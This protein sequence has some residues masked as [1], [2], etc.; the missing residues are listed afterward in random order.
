MLQNLTEQAP[1]GLLFDNRIGTRRE[2]QR[3]ILSSRELAYMLGVSKSTFYRKLK[4]GEF[5]FP[6]IMIAGRKCFVL[7]TVKAWLKEKESLGVS[8][9]RSYKRWQ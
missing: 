8:K 1:K 5:D 3:L 7:D 2:Y 6:F 9:K 4:N